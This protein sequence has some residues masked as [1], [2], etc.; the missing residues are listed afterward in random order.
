MRGGSFGAFPFF[1]V[2]EQ[3]IWK[4]VVGYEGYYLVSSL[5]RIWSIKRNRIMKQHLNQH[6][7]YALRLS[8]DGVATTHEVHR[9]V[10]IAFVPNPLHK[11]CVDHVNGDKTLNIPSNFRWVSHK[12]NSNNTVS[13]SRLRNVMKDEKF[14]K[15]RWSR[16]KE[17]G[18][19]TAP[20]TIYMYNKKGVFI[21]GFQSITE[22]AK[23]IG[24]TN[25]TISVA[26]DSKTR[27]AGG[28]K[29]Y[30]KRVEPTQ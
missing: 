11:A 28:Y 2:M 5:G 18:G 1:I 30:S 4:D 13:L 25:A 8:K 24:K 22:A 16:R 10:A 12:E 7:Y 26:I 14:K 23:Y 19:L 21:R 27:T 29:W 20:K 6:G 17:Q 9:I 15:K 3:E